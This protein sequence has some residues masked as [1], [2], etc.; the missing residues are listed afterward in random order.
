MIYMSRVHRLNSLIL[1]RSNSHA[2]HWNSP[3]LISLSTE[4]WSAYSK[5]KSGNHGEALL[6]MLILGRS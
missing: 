2:S 6:Q 5:G 4:W 3:S 1:Q